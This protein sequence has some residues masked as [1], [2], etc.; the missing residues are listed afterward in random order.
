MDIINVSYRFCTLTVRGHD[1]LLICDTTASQ[2]ATVCN[3]F[4]CEAKENVVLILQSD[5]AEEMASKMV[6]CAGCQNPILELS[7]LLYLQIII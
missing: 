6:S 3:Q 4:L 7:H 2:R 5:F 1:S